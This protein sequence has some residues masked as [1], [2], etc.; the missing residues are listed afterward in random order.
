MKVT[1]KMFADNPT[2]TPIEIMNKISNERHKSN[3]RMPNR[4]E[5]RKEHEI[6]IMENK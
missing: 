1:T 2:L 5:K 4:D 3:K 6:I